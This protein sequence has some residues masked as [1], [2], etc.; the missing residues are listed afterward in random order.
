[1]PLHV[2]PNF[3]A[4]EEV[5]Q[6]RGMTLARDSRGITIKKAQESGGGN[7]G[8]KIV[9]KHSY[10]FLTKKLVP[11]STDTPTVTP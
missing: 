5:T 2:H 4:R 11:T 10:F 3:R 8:P 7:Q 9:P 1:M 6:N